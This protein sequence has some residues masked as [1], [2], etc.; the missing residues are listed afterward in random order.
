MFSIKRSFA[1]Q[2]SIDSTHVGWSYTDFLEQF[3][4]VK[5][6]LSLLNKGENFMNISEKVLCGCSL[7]Q[8][9]VCV[10]HGQIRGISWVQMRAV[11]RIHLLLGLG[12]D[13]LTL[14]GK[15]MR[16]KITEPQLLV[17]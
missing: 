5:S 9:I 14:E 7:L 1:K 3:Q 2:C 15:E 8:F 10:L 17:S 6:G 11:F 16:D 4:F 13:A 12:G